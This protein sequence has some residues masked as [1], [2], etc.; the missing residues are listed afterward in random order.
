MAACAVRRLSAYG[1]SRHRK[2][3]ESQCAACR[4]VSWFGLLRTILGATYSG[5]AGDNAFISPTRRAHEPSR[6]ALAEFKAVTAAGSSEDEEKVP[7]ST[8]P[9]KPSPSWRDWLSEAH[10][11]LKDNPMDSQSPESVALQSPPH[12]PPK[13]RSRALEFDTPEEVLLA[14]AE[15]AEAEAAAAQEL[16]EAKEVAARRCVEAA[17][18]ERRAREAADAREVAMRQQVGLGLGLAAGRG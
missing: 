6:K 14:R 2:P 7:P 11:R 16:S 17:E 8:P 9:A 15:K 3:H 13:R 12:T 18:Q 1:P 4:R 5:T 10:D